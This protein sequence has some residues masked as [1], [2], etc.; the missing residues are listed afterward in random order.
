M[1]LNLGCGRSSLAGWTNV[2]AVALPGVDVV[3]DLDRCREVPLP[4]AD[5][6]VDEFLLAHVIEH[7]A[8]PLGLLQEM[9]RIAKPGAKAVVRCP[10]GSSDDADE[11]PTHRRR[12]FL[13]SFGYFSQP[14][15]W[16]ADYGYRGD[17]QPERIVLFVTAARN[18]GLTAEQILR[19]VH[20]QRNVVVE[21]VA[22]LSAVKPVRTPDRA[23]IRSPRIEIAFA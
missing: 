17:W 6:A 3:A 10:Y 12:M 1:R 14:Y 18:A 21:M 20:E 2:D 16:R 8:D 11:D 23:L 7:L 22:E 13:Q 19:K 9:H 4:F 5:D 15:Y